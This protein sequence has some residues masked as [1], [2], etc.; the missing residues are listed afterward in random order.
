MASLHLEINYVTFLDLLQRRAY[1]TSLT[2]ARGDS[3]VIHADNDMLTLEPVKR[4]T[5]KEGRSTESEL[6]PHMDYH[7]HDQLLPIMFN[8]H[9]YLYSLHFHHYERQM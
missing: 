7:K 6:M 8:D 5:D 2:V 4:L 3:W 1:G 9:I